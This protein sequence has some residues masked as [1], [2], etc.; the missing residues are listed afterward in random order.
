MLRIRI[1]FAPL[2]VILL[3]SGSLH[4]DYFFLK[5]L[6]FDDCKEVGTCDWVFK[7]KLGHE[8]QEWDRLCHDNWDW[9]WGGCGIDNLYVEANTGEAMTPHLAGKTFDSYPVTLFVEVYEHDGGFEIWD[10]DYLDI[11]G[12]VDLRIEG[13]GSYQ[14]T[15]ENDEGK[16]TFFF[17]MVE[18]IEIERAPVEIT[19][20]RRYLGVFE[21]G[22]DN[23]QLAA[24][25]NGNGMDWDDF[26]AT[27]EQN[28]ANGLNLIDVESW[29]TKAGRRYL[30]VYRQGN[31]PIAFSSGHRGGASQA[32]FEQL[33]GEGFELVDFDVY[34]TAYPFYESVYIKTG[35]ESMYPPAQSRDDLFRTWLEH[36][37]NGWRLQDIEIQYLAGQLLFRPTY[38]RGTGPSTLRIT[39]SREGFETVWQDSVAQGLRLIDVEAFPY[40]SQT[41]YVSV[42][43]GRTNGQ[44]FISGQSWDD[45]VTQWSALSGAGYRLIDIETYFTGDPARVLE[46]EPSLFVEAVDPEPVF[47]ALG[48]HGAS[49]QKVTAATPY[50]ANPGGHRFVRGDANANHQVDMTDAIGVLSDLF[51]GSHNI[52][53]DDAADTNDDGAI[54][55]TDAIH[56]LNF[57]YAGQTPPVGAA[58]G[59]TQEDGT[60]D[61]LGCREF[62]EILPL[63]M[64]RKVLKED[65]KAAV[66]ELRHEGTTPPI[67]AAEPQTP[68]VGV[69]PVA[70]PK[71]PVV[72][73]AEPLVP[74]GNPRPVV[75]RTAGRLGVAR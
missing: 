1:L 10:G 3:G 30:G 8:P 57:L 48:Q 5:R 19:P 55:M 74:V 72:E 61:Q 53:C 18:E 38:R 71:R 70:E 29:S 54:V 28:S 22:D 40:G 60:P 42:F 27:F 73:R 11:V 6:Q 9:G 65:E 24:E 25:W 23:H 64:P 20:E 59:A 14:H 35:A 13:P 69:Q 47:G 52:Q 50:V 66:R 43:S 17:D 37:D 68:G 39:D 21:A 36:Y 51:L 16:I 67:V 2:L 34:T 26:V 33:S 31:L 41:A 44:A 49:A 56:I 75:K 45:F 12:A 58:A 7:Y 46:R 15:L 63:P 62:T 4:A 32:E